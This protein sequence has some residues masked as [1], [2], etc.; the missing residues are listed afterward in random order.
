MLLAA[1]TTQIPL[2]AGGKNMRFQRVTRSLR[3]LF[4]KPQD[5]NS[6]CLKCMSRSG[7]LLRMQ[8]AGP[9]VPLVHVIDMEG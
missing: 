8:P 1:W 5:P 6:G 2:K 3:E 7:H 4:I 9:R